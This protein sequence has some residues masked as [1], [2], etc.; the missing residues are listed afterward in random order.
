VRAEYTGDDPL[1]FVVSGNLHRR[2]LSE[3]Q[4]GMV[5]AKMANLP[6]GGAIYSSE[7]DPPNGG[8]LSK[9]AAAK[10][11]NVG[12]RTAERASRVVK[13]GT[14]ELQAAVESGEVNLNQAEQLA[15]L[16]AARQIEVLAEGPEAVKEK[17]KEEAVML[18]MLDNQGGRRNLA[19]IDK[20][21]I[22]RKKEVILAA[23]AKERQ[24]LSGGQGIKGVSESTHL[25]EPG[26]TREGAA[27][28]AGVGQTKY[29]Q[30]KV[31]LDAVESGEAPKELLE[32]VRAGD[33]SVHKAAVEPILIGRDSALSVSTEQNK[34][35]PRL[36]TGAGPMADNTTQN[37]DETEPS[38]PTI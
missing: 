23:R 13:A 38:K 28:E 9:D 24:K 33:V 27:K 22:A 25:N 17:A 34:T 14:P 7:N 11:L 10:M 16:P 3:S 6:H 35:G 2:H 30:G 26:R 37:E 19:D 20:I 4:R 32:Q 21:S 8:S 15:K 1:A 5:A 31:I 12:A 29:D 18:W 36:S